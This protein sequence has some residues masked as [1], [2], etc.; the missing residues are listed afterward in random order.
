[1]SNNNKL[2][3]YNSNNVTA[4]QVQNDTTASFQIKKFEKILI[5]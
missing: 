5:S 2:K 3:C 4:N 1:M